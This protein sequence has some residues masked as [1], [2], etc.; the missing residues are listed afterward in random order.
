MADLEIKW[1]EPAKEQLKSLEADKFPDGDLKEWHEKI[2]R[3]FW[4]NNT[5]LANANRARI[6][7]DEYC[8]S[9]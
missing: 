1:T 7:Y 9:Y 4:K 5:D 6:R 8:S 2:V 3:E